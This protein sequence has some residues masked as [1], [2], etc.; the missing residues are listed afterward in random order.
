MTLLRDGSLSADEAARK[1]FRAAL[2][3]DP[4]SPRAHA[5]MAL[6]WF[7]EWGCQFWDRFEETAR[8]AYE[9]AHAALALDDRDA[10]LHLVLGRIHLYRRDFERASWYLDR[11]LALCPNDAELLIQL[12]LCEGFLGRPEVGVG[13]AERAMRLNPYHPAYYFG[14]AGMVRL[15]AHDFETAAALAARVD[16]L[17]FVDIAAYWA[18]T[19]VSLGRVE[20]ARAH[21]ETFVTSFREKIL[22]GR[23]PAP[24]EAVDWFLKVNPFRRPE[25]T[26]FFAEALSTLDPGQMAHPVSERR[27]APP[28]NAELR[29]SGAGGVAIYDGVTAVVPDLKG[30][31]D[32][33]RLLE[34][35]GEEVHCLDL[36]DR[37]ETA[38]GADVA[39]DDKARAA[40]KTRVR[41]LEEEVEDAEAMNDPGRAERARA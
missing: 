41:D 9:S 29:R 23:D 38:F 24:G 20:P 14:Y 19:E 11:A 3:R 15:I 1:L 2:E 31:D 18:V 36:A 17:P 26:A 4:H 6:S 12:A 13:H 27:P 22:F 35:P 25:D 5:G 34:R 10:A 37:T 32:I 33:R 7:N 16:A 28:M 30:L 21:H 39:L 8:A 40:I